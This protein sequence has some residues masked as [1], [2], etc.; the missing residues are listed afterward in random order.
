MKTAWSNEF[1]KVGKLS[2]KNTKFALFMILQD[3]S[4]L[5]FSQKN[6]MVIL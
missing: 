2:Q 3:I 1:L 4:Q 5:S 6:L